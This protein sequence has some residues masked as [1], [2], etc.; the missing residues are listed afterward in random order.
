ML[1]A[2]NFNGEPVNADFL[3]G[4]AAPLVE[5]GPDKQT[6]Y[7]DGPA[8]M[9]YRAFYTTS[10]S[11]LENQP[12]VPRRGMVSTWDGRLDNRT[13]LLEE[14]RENVGED[15]SDVAIAVA[16][17]ERWG[18]AGFR[19][20]I[21]DWALALWDAGAQALVLARDYIGVRPL[22]YRPHA[23][24][25]FW[26]SH[27]APLVFSGGKFNLCEEYIAGY[28]ALHPD[29]ALTPYREIQ[30]VPPGQ[31]VVIRKA[32]RTTGVHWAFNRDAK[33][34]LK[35]DAEYEERFLVL[36]RQAVRRRL[37][38]KGPIVIQLSGGWDSSSLVCLADDI[39]CQEDDNC[40]VDTFSYYDSREP[41]EDDLAHLLAVE[42]Q[43]S[44][45]G[46]H[47]DLAGAGDSLDLEDKN[48]AAVPGFMTRTEIK[49]ALSVPELKTHRVVISGTGGDEMNGQALN[50]RVM[51]ADLVLHGRLRL[52]WKDLTAWSKVLRRPL[53]Q[54]LS[55]TL[56]E[57]CPLSVRACFTELGKV[58]PWVNAQFAKKYQLSRR[59][60]EPRKSRAI[61]SP[62]ARDS[63]QTVTALANL[64]T[65]LPTSTLE[66][67]YPYLD[68]DLVEF[69]TSIPLEQ[70]L[71]PGQRR[72]LMR[73]SLAKL[74]PP[75]ILSRKSKATAQR[76]YSV[77][78]EK[79]WRRIEQLLEDPLISRLGYV[80][81]TRMY[82]TLSAMKH[83][84]I[85][86]HFLRL[87]KALSLEIWIRDLCER[88][89]IALPPQCTNH[90][91]DAIRVGIGPKPRAGA[92]S[93][94]TCFCTQ[95]R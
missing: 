38:A 59:Q 33:T 52:T 83:G 39:L 68:R 84:I 64:L 61:S 79:H 57:F 16:V 75:E 11:Y 18:A 30:S 10:E 43:R 81:A 48:F 2:W 3:T 53:V 22:F 91:T 25:V 51:L 92:H 45:S 1:G 50:P 60:I 76:C 42:R 32:I 49:A 70:L 5:Y 8:G 88:S 67:R 90:K 54:M 66:Y 31:F 82:S 15:Q 34:R 58:E 27:L 80:N 20:L 26:C 12:Y 93:E 9:L 44:R 19:K 71:R 29:A 17:Y 78:L 40:V 7:I 62:A 23:T 4:M 63:H 14:L 21:G 74:L 41:G 77:S 87:F 86:P 95:N 65:Y 28:L 13:E 56:L 6:S 24:G 72:F 85:S 36:L 69:L 94:S 46:F 73:R 89:L 37:R 35:S 55:E 47:V